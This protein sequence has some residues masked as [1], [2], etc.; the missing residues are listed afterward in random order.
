MNNILGLGSGALI[1]HR[2][3]YGTRLR[4]CLLRPE[5]E[6]AQ[7]RQGVGERRRHPRRCA[8]AGPL[9][10]G[11]GSQGQAKQEQEQ[12]S[13][14]RAYP[15][16]PTYGH[17]SRAWAAGQAWAWA[18][19]TRLAGQPRAG[20]TG[21]REA[22]KGTGRDGAG[23]W[24]QVQLSRIKE[25]N[26]K[27]SE[28]SREQHAVS[29]PRRGESSGELSRDNRPDHE[30]KTHEKVAQA[31]QVST[32]TAA[33]AQSLVNKRPDLAEKVPAGRNKYTTPSL[34]PLYL[35]LRLDWGLE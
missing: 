15:P 23:T 10:A 35:A 29:N 8:G 33:R 27:R 31:A 32:A 20:R 18:Y 14:T 28:A 13:M 34:L 30:P 3:A 21:K 25:A 24:R 17:N 19:P 4:L 16:L 26:R 11:Q 22:Q 9:G 6:D 7:G 5:E 12:G 1:K 2:G